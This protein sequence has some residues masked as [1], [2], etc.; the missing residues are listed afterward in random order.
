L[1]V[2]APAIELLPARFSMMLLL[3]VLASQLEADTAGQRDVSAAA[4][5][6]EQSPG[7]VVVVQRDRL[8]AASNRWRPW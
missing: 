6:L 2:I 8:A 4:V 3:L 7:A 5:E 1:K